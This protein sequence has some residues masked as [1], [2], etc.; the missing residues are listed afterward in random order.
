MQTSESEWC[1]GVGEVNFLVSLQKLR[2]ADIICEF[3]TKITRT[4]DNVLIKTYQK[5]LDSHRITL[6]FVERYLFYL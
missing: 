1:G 3:N 6:D 4:S 5:D 2:E